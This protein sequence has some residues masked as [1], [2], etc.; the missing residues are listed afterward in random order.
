MSVFTNE[1]AYKYMSPSPTVEL[2]LTVRLDMVP[3]WGHQIEDHIELIFDR[4]PYVVSAEIIE[5]EN[6]QNWQWSDRSSATSVIADILK[7]CPPDLRELIATE[8][9]EFAQPSKEHRS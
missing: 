7:R 2:K 4:D 1:L 3:G 9:L 5:H 8:A 6:W